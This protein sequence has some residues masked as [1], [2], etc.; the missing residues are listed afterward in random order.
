MGN[1]F[2]SNKRIKKE[3]SNIV[4]RE[5]EGQTPNQKLKSNIST[6]QET[7]KALITDF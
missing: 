2:K 6:R 3:V 5:S 1:N 7:I 4:T